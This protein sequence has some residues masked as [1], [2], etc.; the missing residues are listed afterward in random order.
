MRRLVI[1]V[2]V[3]SAGVLLLVN[4][5]A[6]AGGASAQA[7][8]PINVR[9]GCNGEEVGEFF[10]NNQTAQLSKVAGDTARFSLLGNSDVTTVQVQPK[11]DVRWPF[12][13]DPPEFGSG[14]DAGTG[15]IASD[16]Q[17]GIYGYDLVVTCGTTPD[18]IDPNMDIDG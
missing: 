18:V 8:V 10:I 5:W 16:V 15:A 9:I 3:L 11:E 13:D 2:L 7:V 12:V 6:S 14:N 1:A 4:A 17:P